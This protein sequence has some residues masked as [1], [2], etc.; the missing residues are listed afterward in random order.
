LT[1]EREK[2]TKRLNNELEKL[3][4]EKLRLEESLQLQKTRWLYSHYLLWL[5]CL[6]TG[7]G[8]IIGNLIYIV[9]S[10]LPSTALLPEAARTFAQASY[11]VLY[12]GFPIFAYIL[13]IVVIK[14]PE[15]SFK[16]WFVYCV[17]FTLF[18]GLIFYVDPLNQF[19]SQY[20][21]IERLTQA[22]AAML[23]FPALA[24]GIF[25][26][27]V[28]RFAEKCGYK[29]A[30]DGSA[31]SFEVDADLPT[32]SKQLEKLEEDFRFVQVTPSAKPDQLHFE[33]LRIYPSMKRTF[34][35]VFLQ[36]RENKT[37]VV[38]VMH[39]VKND[40]PMRTARKEVRKIGETLMKWLGVSKDF[41]VL[42]TENK[43]LADDIIQES[44]K[45]FY[46]QPVTLPSAR[47]VKRFFRE[48]WRN[49]IVII[50]F[51]VAVLSWLFPR[52]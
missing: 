28:Q 11:L 7:Y 48:H 4:D 51:I 35:Q 42:K 39:S 41:A 24:M 3:R 43:R 16:T 29:L 17:S 32:V 38:L 13:Y 20:E 33:K 34:L 36:S 2:N 23:F 19:L 18:A 44:K 9:M 37:D 21:G 26:L 1:N 46:R 30:L 49:I 10:V 47:S 45:S 15:F 22:V 50:S 25:S 40:I 12:V 52:R 14:A 5:V 27:F 6:G 8:A 31:F